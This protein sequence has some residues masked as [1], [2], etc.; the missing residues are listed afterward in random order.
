[1]RDDQPK[2]SFDFIA[3]VLARFTSNKVPGLV[4]I[5]LV[6]SFENQIDHGRPTDIDL[7]FLLD[8]RT[9]EQTEVIQLEFEQICRYC[10]RHGFPCQLEFRW[11]PF[12]APLGIV[13]FHVLID[14]L[15]TM[16]DANIV[17]MLN[18]RNQAHCIYGE[19]LGSQQ[20]F[21]GYS[22]N[23][24]LDSARKQW[25]NRKFCVQHDFFY[26]KGLSRKGDVYVLEKHRLD[27]QDVWQ[28]LTHIKDVVYHSIANYLVISEDKCRP[29]RARICETIFNIDQEHKDFCEILDD[30]IAGKRAMAPDDM[31]YLKSAAI[32]IID[33]L[34]IRVDRM[35]SRMP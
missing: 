7:Y 17:T 30:L 25:T 8:R 16:K 20:V 22:C 5:S 23:S 4:S 26:Y 19:E 2:S 31:A 3:P 35:Q 29:E 28:F 12:K 13:Q 14:S 6:G 27:I 15:E 18:W 9:A 34:L 24:L 10:S 21:Q 1:M 32:S 11:G 33:S